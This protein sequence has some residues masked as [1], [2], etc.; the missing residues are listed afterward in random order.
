MDENIHHVIVRNVR[1]YQ[2]G[3]CDIVRMLARGG[4]QIY[5]V[6]LDGIMDITER[7]DE[8]R[9]LAGIRIGDLSDYPLRLNKLGE[10]RNIVVRN[11][12]TRA[13]FG[14]YIANTLADATFENINFYDDCGVGMFFNGCEL[15]N[16][17]VRGINYDTT[18]SA[19]E[20]DLGYECIFH[21]VEVNSLDA[22]HFDNCKVD[23]VLFDRVISG[24]N[25]ANVFASNTPIEIEASHVTMSDEKTKLTE[26][27]TIK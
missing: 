26:N 2:T 12:S 7:G 17:T 21:R 13:R 11:V 8:H 20:S 18:T 9:P 14:C 24:E 4:T 16:I 3:E 10:M 15:K 6:L 5:N 1:S 25:I 23:N 22:V 27:V 19:P